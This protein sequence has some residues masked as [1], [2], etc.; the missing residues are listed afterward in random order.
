MS[1]AISTERTRNYVRQIK[2]AVVYKAIAMLASF[3]YIPLMIH[4][5]GQEQFGILATLLSVMSWVVFF[6]LGVGNGLRN[7]VA[8]ALA[9]NEKEEAGQYVASGYTLIGIIAVALWL[10]VTVA[11]HF[12][13]WQSVFNTLSVS[14][15]TLRLTVQIAAFFIL[16]NFWLGLIG[17]LKEPFTISGTGKQVRDVLHAEDMKRLYAA[18]VINISKAKGQAFNIGGGIANSLSLLELFALLEEIADVKLSYTKL[19]V[20]ESDQR[21]FVADIAKANKLLGWKPAVSSREGVARMFEWV[22]AL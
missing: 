13:P 6:D 21:V 17:A 5:L 2:G 16:L 15:K 4:Y 10:L 14:E 8:E 12:I 19:P 3:M 22:N 20:R 9:R 1:E 18:A 7:K 11:A